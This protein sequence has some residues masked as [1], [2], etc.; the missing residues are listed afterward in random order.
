MKVLLQYLESFRK[1]RS[2]HRKELCLTSDS[3]D[4]APAS[5]GMLGAIATKSSLDMSLSPRL[6]LAAIATK[7]SLDMSLSQPNFPSLHVCTTLQG[8]GGSLS[9]VE[10]SHGSNPALVPYQSKQYM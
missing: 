6:V 10:F 5:C 1:H 7:S 4:S 2:E 9:A 3:C 8:L